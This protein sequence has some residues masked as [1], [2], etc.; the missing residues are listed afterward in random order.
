MQE[1]VEAP[2]ELLVEEAGEGRG[3]EIVEEPQELVL[4]PFPTNNPLLVATSTDQVYIFPTPKAYPTPKT[5]SPNVTSFALPWLHNFRKLVA[6]AQTFATTSQKMT[7]A[8]V[9]WHNGWFGCE[10]GHGALE[11]RH[12]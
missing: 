10:F 3:K 9:A 6:I 11:P 5:P 2:E 7:A 1:P 12:F 8:D 4:N